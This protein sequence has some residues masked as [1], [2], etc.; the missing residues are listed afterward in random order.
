MGLHRVSILSIPYALWNPSKILESGIDRYYF[1]S[2]V[3][4]ILFLWWKVAEEKS[5]RSIS[6]VTFLRNLACLLFYTEIGI[7]TMDLVES[8]MDGSCRIK[9]KLNCQELERPGIKAAGSEGQEQ[10]A[11]TRG[12]WISLG[13]ASWLGGK[14]RY[15]LRKRSCG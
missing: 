1:L 9:Y 14:R 5:I 15:N 10:I 12:C 3:I 13:S 4:H 8:S 11:Y 2:N 6:N 7:Y